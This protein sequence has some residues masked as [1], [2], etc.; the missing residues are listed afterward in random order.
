ML[1]LL[2]A[3]R[4]AGAGLCALV[5]SV[6]SAAH[7][8]AV[9]A[10]P[11]A[12]AGTF[13]KAAIGITHG[14]KG[15]PTREVIIN[16]PTGVQGAKPMPKAGWTV[17]ITRAK[18]EQPRSSHGRTITEEVTQ[19]RYSGG[20]LPNDHYD[21]FT[22]VGTLPAQAGMLWWKVSQVCEQGRHDWDQVPAAGQD[23]KSLE[24]PALRLEV[25]PG[26]HAGH[27]H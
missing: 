21:E 1:N 17:T 26:A 5:L 15:L 3:R 2:S 12:E 14:C 11:K 19:I 24:S 25:T 20:A 13:Y 10:Q 27:Q 7:A 18:L 6:P 23:A 8:H 4:G 22:V 16:I 9:L